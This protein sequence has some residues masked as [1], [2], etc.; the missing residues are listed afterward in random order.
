MSIVGRGD[1]GD[2]N[3]VSVNWYINP[4]LIIVVPLQ[5][6]RNVHYGNNCYKKSLFVKTPQPPLPYAE[7]VDGGMCMIV[8][9]A[10]SG[11]D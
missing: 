9:N 11:T 5:R 10:L 2:N 1:N 4:N 3:H 6:N 7:V 8:N